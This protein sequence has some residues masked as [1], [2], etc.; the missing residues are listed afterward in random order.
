MKR[1]FSILILV[2]CFSIVISQTSKR[3]SAYN[4]LRNGKLDK[5][6]EYID[7]T[8]NHEKTMNNAKTWFYRGNI[9]LQIALSNNPD[10]KALDPNALDVAYKSFIKAKELDSHQE[11]LNDITT[12]IRVIAEQYYN[13]GVAKYNEKDFEV[14]GTSFENAYL[15]N[16]EFGRVDS[17]ALF[18]AALSAEIAK[19]F[20]QAMKNYQELMRIHFDRPIIYSSLAAIYK[21]K[22]DTATAIMIIKKGRELY[23]IN[24]DLLIAETN[25]Y[26]A[27]GDIENALINLEL[28]IEQDT[29][30][31]SI[32]FAVG[33]KYDE[34]GRYDDAEK[35][36]KRAI[37]L[38]PDYFDANYNLGA[39]YVNKAAE[40]LEIANNLPIEENE[41]YN[42]LKNE[43]DNL[44]KAS[45]PYLE[46]A[47]EINPDER[48]T[49]LSL[50]D[51]Y[52]RM[53]M[54][55]KLEEVDKKLK[56]EG[57]GEGEGKDKE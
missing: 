52:A 3:T 22:E 40:I 57:E 37:K 19:N 54:K 14:A 47:L 6:K 11:Y 38:D 10:Y 8:I 9:Y 18:N 44:L 41:K 20:D 16:K 30:N 25:I 53:N 46:K 33:T 31:P 1:I 45:I 21:E 42:K 39:L 23:P 28:A 27:A 51:I 36:F 50:K 29:T 12:N 15:I 48:N 2:F 43:A 34:S 32:Y 13:Q 17:T 35:S 7:P 24:F 4:Y 49:L 56:S 55:E 5:A 26:L